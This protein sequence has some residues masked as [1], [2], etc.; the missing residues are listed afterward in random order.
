MDRPAFELAAGVITEALSSGSLLDVG[1]YEGAFLESLPDDFSKYGIEP[2][3]E[4]RHMAN[5]RG[6]EMVGRSLSQI[7]VD[8]AMFHCITLLDVFEHLPR[9][10]DS[11]KT[12]V[13]LL[14]PGGLVVVATG[15]TDTFLWRMMRRD[16]WYYFPEHVSFANPRWFVWAA[17]ELHMKIV[18]IKRFSH[19]TGSF[20]KK[21][22]Q[23]AHCLAYSALK[24]IRPFERVHRLASAFYP[25]SKARQW[26]S[27]PLADLVSDHM[28]VVLKSRGGTPH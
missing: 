21:W 8:R 9:P 26:A 5:Q 3:D 27:A 2:S 12:L 14:L 20:I 10:M 17:A 6:I 22:R 4:G 16:Y 13:N 18:M 28:I 19:V 23:I 11:F 7:E 1:C 25:F 15:N 24:G